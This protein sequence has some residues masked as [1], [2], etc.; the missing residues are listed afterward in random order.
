MTVAQD[1]HFAE[2]RA[3]I[4]DDRDLGV[5]AKNLNGAA[6]KD[7]EAAGRIALGEENVAGGE[8]PARGAG[9]SVED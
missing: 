7:I 5:A 3:W 2:H 9:A 1:R 8:V 6:G 4:A